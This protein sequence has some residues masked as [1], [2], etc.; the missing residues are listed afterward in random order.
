MADNF[1]G[2][3]EKLNEHHE[4]F[5]TVN[6]IDTSEAEHVVLAVLENGTP[7][8]ALPFEM[9]PQWFKRYLPSITA[10]IKAL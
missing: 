6:I 2:N 10:K 3:L 4:M 8:S 9:L 7:T 5:Q 1:Y